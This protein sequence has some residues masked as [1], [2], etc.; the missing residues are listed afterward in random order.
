MKLKFKCTECENIYS[1]DGILED[2]DESHDNTDALFN[3]EKYHKSKDNF[4]QLEC[5]CY[6]DKFKIL[7]S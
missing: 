6:N 5:D 4:K 1:Q 3:N 2:A 7:Y